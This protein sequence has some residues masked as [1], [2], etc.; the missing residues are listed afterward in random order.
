M[1]CGVVFTSGAGTSTWGPITSAIWRMNARESRSSSGSDRT[2]G[3]TWTPGSAPAR[4]KRRR[5]VELGDWV[6]CDTSVPHYH[7]GGAMAHGGS[8][9]ATGDVRAAPGARPEGERRDRSV[10]C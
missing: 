4:A 2:L 3:S 7:R 1:I 9:G 5:R 8:D 6:L 10:E